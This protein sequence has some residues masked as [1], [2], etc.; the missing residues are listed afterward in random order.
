LT[1]ANALTRG[2]LAAHASDYPE[3]QAIL[4]KS[5]PTESEKSK[6]LRYRSTEN[7][8]KENTL[9]RLMLSIVTIKD[10]QKYKVAKDRLK[11]LLTA[12]NNTNPTRFTTETS[13]DEDIL[14]MVLGLNIDQNKSLR[15]WL[16]PL[17]IKIRKLAD[18]AEVPELL[19]EIDYLSQTNSSHSLATTP[20]S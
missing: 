2:Y 10:Y 13:L 7:L 17:K 8:I 18:V 6:I 9:Y 14:K 19:T 4:E 20:K 11:S 16:I 5:E 1:R 3:M 12:I 15:A